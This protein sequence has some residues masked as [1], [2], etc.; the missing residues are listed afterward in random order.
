MKTRPTTKQFDV[1][2]VQ[3]LKQS[4]LFTQ[5]KLNHNKK[6]VSQENT[7]DSLEK[8]IPLDEWK[9]KGFFI[10]DINESKILLDYDSSSKLVMSS[11]D[12]VQSELNQFIQDD[13]KVDEKTIQELQTEFILEP[14]ENP[15]EFN[16]DIEYL[17][18]YGIDPQ[19]LINPYELNI[20]QWNR[21][22]LEMWFCREPIENINDNPILSE[23]THFRRYGKE[24][25]QYDFLCKFSKNRSY[26][27]VFSTKINGNQPLYD[28]I[29]QQ[30]EMKND[31]IQFT[32]FHCSSSVY[33]ITQNTAT[34]WIRNCA[35]QRILEYKKKLATYKWNWEIMGLFL[36]DEYLEEDQ[37]EN[38]VINDSSENPFLC[39]Y[40]KVHKNIS[41][42]K[43]IKPFII[44]LENRQGYD[45]YRHYLDQH[46]D[47]HD[48]EEKQELHSDIK[49]VL[50][51][52]P[53][54]TI[55]TEED[56]EMY[57]NETF[58]QIDKSLP[59]FNKYSIYKMSDLSKL[60]KNFQMQY[61]NAEWI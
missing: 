11:M 48:H 29:K 47:H 19:Y 27:K 1:N 18:C 9:K 3:K 46:P 16:F 56:G 38:Q 43:C 35:L 10:E 5:Q 32:N 55:R 23:I 53:N 41:E 4:A 28:Q 49:P 26:A 50:L 14:G 34:I 33:Q 13:Q 6:E 22:L 21:L 8:P 36:L 12:I 2:I 20:N 52:T 25:K 39:Q 51:S 7:T 30:R 61:E 45:E 44:P 57:F 59:N 15:Y 24:K 40:G 60:I 31:L 42:C 17:S 37:R 54:I 58:N